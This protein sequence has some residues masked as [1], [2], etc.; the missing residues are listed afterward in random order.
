MVP[1][2][3]MAAA[4]IWSAVGTVVNAMVV[5]ILAI[6]NWRYLTAAKRQATAAE[7]QAK[8]IAEQTKAIRRQA[9]L[10][11][12]QFALSVQDRFAHRME[13]IRVSIN[14]LERLKQEVHAFAFAND[15]SNIPAR[16]IDLLPTNWEKVSGCLREELISP[17]IRYKADV[18]Y[19][20]MIGFD[21][22]YKELKTNGVAQAA[23]A[24]KRCRHRAELICDS[25][26]DLLRQLEEKLE[27]ETEEK[28]NAPSPSRVQ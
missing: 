2:N 8:E 25:V 26:A 11:D 12:R 13:N 10:I 7:N 5:I 19:I 21:K 3:G 18:L 23:E 9:E 22:N 16:S 4:E 27:H 20:H 14:T 15:D 1:D 24:Q 6:L 17:D 28:L